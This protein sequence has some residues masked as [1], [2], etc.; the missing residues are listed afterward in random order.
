MD[1]QPST[2]REFD[3][4]HHLRCPRHQ[5]RSLRGRDL[6]RGRALPGVDRVEVDLEH[7]RVAVTGRDLDDTAIRAA[8]YE[9]G[10][11]AVGL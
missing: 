5:L 9:A 11:E 7:K 10:Y 2:R 3:E 4:N 6:G 8:I 1:Q